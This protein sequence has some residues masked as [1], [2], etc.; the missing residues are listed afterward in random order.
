MLKYR[1]TRVKLIPCPENILNYE[2]TIA[3]ARVKEITVR[4]AAGYG[5][6]RSQ[7]YTKCIC[8]TK[9][10]TNIC[11]CKKNNVLYFYVIQSVTAQQIVK[12]NNY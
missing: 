12:I 9:C 2:K 8:E 11:T 5:I 4:E 10:K 1:F 3:T 6:A 7:G